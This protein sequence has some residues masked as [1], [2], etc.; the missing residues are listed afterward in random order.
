MFWLDIDLKTRVATLH[1]GE[2]IHI[3]PKA[4]E[5]RG[6]NEMRA[7]GGWFSFETAGEAMRFHKS[8]KL[9]GEVQTCLL[10]KPLDHIESVDIAKFDIST[11]RTGCDACATRVE[12]MDT[13]ST[14]RRLVDK[15][16]GPK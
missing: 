12:V 5:T 10:C 11:P 13:K 9:S 2:C 1:R 8:K 6:V 16:L 15:L 14:Y 4:T 3:S 7:D